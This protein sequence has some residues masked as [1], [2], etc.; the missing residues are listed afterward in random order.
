MA[1]PS[2]FCEHKKLRST[3][4]LCGASRAGPAPARGPVA[5]DVDDAWHAF[6]KET[7]AR[8]KRLLEAG[9][10]PG[11]D[12]SRY[13]AIYDR[14]PVKKGRSEEETPDTYRGAFYLGMV[15]LFDVTIEGRRVQGYNGLA[16]W[17]EMRDFVFRRHAPDAYP[18]LVRDKKLLVHGGNGAWARQQILTDLVRHERLR[19]VVGLVCF[20]RDGRDPSA[21]TDDEALARLRDAERINAEVG[22]TQSVLPFASRL[23]HVFD[24]TRWPALTARTTPEAGAALGVGLPEVQTPE[25]YLAFARAL[26]AFAKAK[27][28]ADLDRVDILLTNE[29]DMLEAEGDDEELPPLDE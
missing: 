12:A 28:H 8:L 25:D 23:L 24:A 9:R 21:I 26:R 1:A 18:G 10:E 4:A 5:H 3:C 11:W 17:D 7:H 2:L 15:K 19:E 13:Y 20:G 22:A 16:D 29:A 6:R 14:P 27:G